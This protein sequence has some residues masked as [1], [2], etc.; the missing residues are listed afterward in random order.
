MYN[1]ANKIL[2][3]LPSYIAIYND[4]TS[5]CHLCEDITN[6]KGSTYEAQPTH[7]PE[8]DLKNLLATV[9]VSTAWMYPCTT[10]ARMPA[11]AST[12]SATGKFQCL[13]VKI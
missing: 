1:C 2:C 4:E 7:H 3:Y 8:Q 9:G 11:L 5:S 12:N 13:N 6:I 10:S